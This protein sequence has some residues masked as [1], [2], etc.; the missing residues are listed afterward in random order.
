MNMET[1]FVF[2]ENPIEIVKSMTNPEDVERLVFIDIDK[3]IESLSSCSDMP[4]DR[5]YAIN[6]LQ[7]CK[8]KLNVL[9]ECIQ[10]AEQI[11][12]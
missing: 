12:D 11:E 2:E 6:V 10:A 1:K 3:A 4:Q 5:L 7:R 8:R 9:L